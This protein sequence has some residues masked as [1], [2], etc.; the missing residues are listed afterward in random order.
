MAT[1]IPVLCLF[2]LLFLFESLLPS[3]IVHLGVT[4][5]LSAVK[6][7]RTPEM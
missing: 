7:G 4:L 1:N 6:S 3:G 2:Q 5:V